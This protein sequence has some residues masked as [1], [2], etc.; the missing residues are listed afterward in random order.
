MRAAELQV[1]AASRYSDSLDYESRKRY[2]DEL[3]TDY[4]VLPD[5][6]SVPDDQ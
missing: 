3:K 1:M 2:F 4:E 5:P 6:Y